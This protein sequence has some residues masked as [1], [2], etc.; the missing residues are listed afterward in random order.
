MIFAS[1]GSMLPFD[2]LTR[3]V[4]EWAGANPSTPVFLQIGAGQYV[5]RH[6]QWA[7]MVPHEDYLLRLRQCDLFVAHV[8]IGSIVQ[9]LEIGT[10]MIM[11]PR[12]ASLGEHTTEHQLHTAARFGDSPGLTIVDDTQALQGAMSEFAGQPLAH[13]R[14]IAAFAPP[15]MTDRI[16]LFINGA[17]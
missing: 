6:A 4:D 2:R 5:P 12:L 3:A 7:R 1:V 13:E 11:L 14:R 8:G 10:R 9:A 17:L 15:Q 16:R